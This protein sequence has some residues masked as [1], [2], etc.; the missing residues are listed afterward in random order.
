MDK[1]HSEGN[2]ECDEKNSFQPESSPAELAAAAATV[3][4]RQALSSHPQAQ[5]QAQ[6]Q[7]QTNP[8]LEEAAEE[9]EGMEEPEGEQIGSEELAELILPFARPGDVCDQC[10]DPPAK[11]CCLTGC[12]ERL[13][14]ECSKMLHAL[15]GLANH[16]IIALEMVQECALAECTKPATVF[17]P[18]CKAE[19]CRECR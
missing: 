5:A 17:C 3:R 15:P 18:Q 14:L 8:Q 4:T 9:A 13:C 12:E 2:N 10:G 16:S 7:A 11:V 19:F 6:A 1:S